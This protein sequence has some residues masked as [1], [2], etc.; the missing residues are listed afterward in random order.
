MF[1]DFKNSYTED[2]PGAN[3]VL[4]VCEYILFHCD[5]NKYYITNLKLQKL[6][7]F[8]EAS[9]LLKSKGTEACFKEKI[10]A[11]DY[12]PVVSE[13]YDKYR[14]YGSFR[15]QYNRQE[16][17]KISNPEYIN[18]VLEKMAGYNAFKLVDITHAQEPW[19]KAYEARNSVISKQSIYD[20]FRA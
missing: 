9:Y 10:L 12:G 14:T 1:I 6:L 4:K 20:F 8:C 16:E 13:V 11:W 7:Y 19:K 2:I 17:P 3:N 15:I 18:N 5:P